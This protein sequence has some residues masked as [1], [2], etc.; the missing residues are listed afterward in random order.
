MRFAGLV[1]FLLAAPLQAFEPLHIQDNSFLLEEAYNQ[2]PGV[3]QYISS[4]IADDGEYFFG[5]TNEIPLGGQTHQFSYTLTAA[6][7]DEE[8]GISDALINYR[9]QL[10]GDGT[11][12]LAIAPRISLVVPTGDEERGL[13]GGEWGY[14]FNLPVSYVLSDRFVTHWN[15]G[16]TSADRLEWFAGASLIAAP[17]RKFHVMLETLF[18]D[19]E[20]EGSDF[21]VSPGVRWAWDLKNGFQVVPGVAVP[22]GED[23]TAVLFYLSLER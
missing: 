9:Y 2:E 19:D 23:S 4:L 21:V 16:L 8:S 13:G 22:I 1:L 12:R 11:T 10:A 7:L 14:A 3:I 15:A 18:T 6:S 5:F 20:D 17:Y